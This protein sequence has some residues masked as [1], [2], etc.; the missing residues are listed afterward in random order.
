MSRQKTG[1]REKNEKT[2]PVIYFT[3]QKKDT[4]TDLRR[5]AAQWAWLPIVDTDVVK[6]LADAKAAQDTADGKRRTFI[7]D[8]VP[9]Y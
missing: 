8:P 9:P 3:T 4:L 1:Q 5:K 2:M 6:A 7:T